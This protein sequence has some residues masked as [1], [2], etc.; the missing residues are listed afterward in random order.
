M[1]ILIIGATG[2]I[3]EQ[4][5]LNLHRQGESPIA[6]VRRLKEA[7]QQLGGDI[8]YRH[9]NFTVPAGFPKVLEGIDRLFFI[10][11]NMDLLP[12]VQALLQAAREAGVQQIVYSSGRTT[13]DVEGKP[14]HQ[15][16]KTV[17]ASGIPYTILRPGWFM[18]NF[19]SWLGQ[20]IPTEG[21]IYLPAGDSKTA[22]I[23]V[24]DIGA[25]AARVLTEDSHNGRI[26]GLTSDEALDHHQVAAL[27]GDAI[28]KKVNYEPLEP[29]AFINLMVKKGW[30][31]EAA[32]YTESL[33]QYVRRG[34][35]AE[36]SPD[37]E[38]VLGRKPIRFAQFVKDYRDAWLS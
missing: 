11:P 7:Q 26:Y 34:K 16:E 33:F 24:R 1:R 30:S 15:F 9:F 18:Q 4:I 37:V 22:F 3:G 27:I 8:E 35:E 25:V 38:F 17:Q 6:A 29:E 32:R 36:P 20:W 14:L 13:G 10:A 19:V 23:D 5:I 21:K 2:N 28:G 31:E 12:L